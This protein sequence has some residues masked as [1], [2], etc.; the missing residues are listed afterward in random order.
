MFPRRRTPESIEPSPLLPPA[1]PQ[2]IAAE[3]VDMHRAWMAME[4]D[5][6]PPDE[7]YQVKLAQQAP[8]ESYE[9]ELLAEI[10]DR[11]PPASTRVIEIGTGWGGL[12]IL[13]ARFG[14]EIFGFEGNE[15]RYIA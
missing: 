1:T 10:T 3:L 5:K 13:L 6:Y 12:A 2:A 4:A 14:Y 9:L 8:L 11:Y 7:L 15:R